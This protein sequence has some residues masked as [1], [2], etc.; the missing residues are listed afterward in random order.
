LPHGH[1]ITG[2][3]NKECE[4]LFPVSGIVEPFSVEYALNNAT[5]GHYERAEPFNSRIVVS[6]GSDGKKNITGQNPYS[7]MDFGKAIYAELH[8][9]P[10]TSWTLQ[11]GWTIVLG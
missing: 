3:S 7:G 11:I 5:D 8:G 10:Y 9:T 1:K 4:I 2:V 6:K